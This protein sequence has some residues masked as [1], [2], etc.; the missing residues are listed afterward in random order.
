MESG[1]EP[2]LVTPPEFVGVLR[3]L[4]DREPIFHRPE[5]GTTRADFERMTAPDFWET[6]A[7]GRRYS[8]A[9]VLDELDRRYGQANAQGE[10]GDREWQDDPWEASE[11]CCRKL[12]A[13]VYLLTY[14]LI[15][16]QAAGPRRTRRT[17]IWERTA[18]GWRI[19]Y[20]QGTIVE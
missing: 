13:E 5:H 15:Q 19:L 12:A 3:E 2:E 17:T 6:G 20:H 4:M 7:S 1:P 18:H 14:T 16:K 9:F 10:S 8:R 11:F